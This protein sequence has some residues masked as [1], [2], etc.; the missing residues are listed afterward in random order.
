[1]H[2]TTSDFTYCE[3]DDVPKLTIKKHITNHISV[4]IARNALCGRR[5]FHVRSAAHWSLRTKEGS[6]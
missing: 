2:K 5:H 4:P 6:G 3:N 1:M